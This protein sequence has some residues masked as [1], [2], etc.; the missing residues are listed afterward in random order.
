M[1]SFAASGNTAAGSMAMFPP[2]STS[3]DDLST[4][5]AEHV[6]LQLRREGLP[7]AIAAVIRQTKQGF[8]AVP[9]VAK[10][11]NFRHFAFDTKALVGGNE[12]QAGSCD[13]RSTRGQQAGSEFTE[14]SHCYG[15]QWTEV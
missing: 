8:V 5:V 4:L 11:R 6:L 1:L 3:A 14:R 2:G 7:G 12:Q 9:S 15:W 13:C 10:A